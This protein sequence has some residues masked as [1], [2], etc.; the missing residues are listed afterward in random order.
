MCFGFGKH[1]GRKVTEVLD[2]EPGY[3]GWVLNADFPLYTKKLL[4]EI[5]LQTLNS[6]P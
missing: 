1:K 4:T 5:R 3:F 6:K 2:T